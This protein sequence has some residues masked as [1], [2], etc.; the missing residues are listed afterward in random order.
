MRHNLV[1][2]AVMILVVALVCTVLWI[3]FLAAAIHLV[4]CSMSLEVESEMH[5][6]ESESLP[7]MEPTPTPA[8]RIN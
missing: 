3:M 5:H 7:M 4:G 1:E 8:A 2:T 6:H